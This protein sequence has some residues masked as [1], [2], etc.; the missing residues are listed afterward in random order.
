MS[1]G[2]QTM[3]ATVVKMSLFKLKKTEFPFFQTGSPLLQVA[4]QGELRACLHGGVGPQV[5][6][7]TRLSI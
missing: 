2:F 3:T 6:E 4:L 7:V 1:Q 5:G